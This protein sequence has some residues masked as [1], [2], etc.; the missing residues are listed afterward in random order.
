MRNDSTD[1]LQEQVTLV[2]DDDKCDIFNKRHPKICKWYRDF[3][4]CKFTL[5]CKFKHENHYE[6]FEKFDKKFEDLK[7]M[8]TNNVDEDLAKKAVEKLESVT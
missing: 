8:P 1:L 3:R 7:S 5:G 2:W 4:W 6:I